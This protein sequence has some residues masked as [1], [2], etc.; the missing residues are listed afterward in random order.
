MGESQKSAS[1][2]LHERLST[3]VVI[4]SALLT[5]A[6][7]ANAQV[8]SGFIVMFQP[9]T[10]EAARAGSAQ[11][12]GAVMRFNYSIV[13]A[14]AI[15]AVDVNALA[16]LQRDPSVIAII[17]DWPIYGDG[18]QLPLPGPG[19]T[20]STSQTIPAGVKRVGVPRPAS[21]G[22]GIGIAVIDTGIDFGHRDL[23]PAAQWFT[24]VGTSCQDD[25]GHGTHVTGIA[26]AL[27]NA[28]DV[29]GV[30]PKAK[31]YCVKVLDSTATGSD[32]NIIAGLDWV[33]R[34]Y[35]IVSPRIR[36]VN[37]S[38][39]RNGTLD[40]DPALRAA[41]RRLY[42]LGLVMMVAAGNDPSLEVSQRV[43][44]GYPEV[45]AIAA[46]TAVSGQNSCLL[47]QPIRADT[48]T[49]FT[50]DGH[51][52]RNTRIGITISAPG[53]EEEDI[54]FLCMVNGLGILSTQ[55]GGGTTRLSGTSMATPHVTGIVARLMQ[56]GM[57]G[58]ENIRGF[59][60]SS[61]ARIGI[62]PL[63]SSASGYTFDDEREGIAQAP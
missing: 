36:A 5:F 21:N 59:L 55:L 56:S 19:T 4:L 47:A 30:A 38:L 48:A 18:A 57:S 20:G 29:V 6:G 39:G 33:F 7:P 52:D 32:S 63:D 3:A 37:M 43:P 49:Y 26:A 51:Y 50:T 31:P 34:N 54:N 42:D 27:D 12:A 17:P 62:A 24:A 44:A 8:P 16:I 25:H 45:L 9:G 28:V 61:A 1:R 60:R 35:T 22:D 2:I 10:A 40:D 15:D 58:V 53:D 23:A 11:R 14:I 41:I 46:T 13:D